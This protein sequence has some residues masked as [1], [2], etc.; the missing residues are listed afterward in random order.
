[1]LRKS[2]LI[3]LRVC[4]CGGAQTCAHLFVWCLELQQEHLLDLG[5]SLLIY[6]QSLCK[7]L[8][9]F[10]HT[11]TIWRTH[12][13]QGTCIQGYCAPT[14]VTTQLLRLPSDPLILRGWITLKQTGTSS[15]EL[16]LMAKMLRKWYG[17]YRNPNTSTTII[18]V[19][20]QWMW[21]WR[22]F[23]HVWKELNKVFSIPRLRS[24][25]SNKLPWVIFPEIVSAYICWPPGCR[26]NSW[27]SK[28]ISQ[29]KLLLVDLQLWVM[30][31]SRG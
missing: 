25:K 8:L 1:M 21:P 30:N 16:W 2:V 24:M 13:H 17:K 7:V 23:G 4:V 29:A 28:L 31:K 3:C 18:S 20:K 12:T 5:P 26:N 9:D 27:H 6:I 10:S 19:C 11:D 22:V 15:S 14:L